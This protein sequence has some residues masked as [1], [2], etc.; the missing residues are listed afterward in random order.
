MVA[1]AEG[2]NND[3]DYD[4]NDLQAVA[5]L[6]NDNMADFDW[7]KEIV[8]PSVVTNG[9]LSTFK[10]ESGS[11]LQSWDD[12][13][14]ANISSQ[15]R[16]RSPSEYV[17]NYSDG[18]SYNSDQSM[19]D[20]DSDDSAAAADGDADDDDD[21]N[22]CKVKEF[23]PK[24]VFRGDTAEAVEEPLSSKMKKNKSPEEEEIEDGLSG[25]EQEEEYQPVE[26]LL[27]LT[28]EWS[29]GK[30]HPPE[31]ESCCEEL[32]HQHRQILI[33]D[34]LVSK[35]SELP[36]VPPFNNNN[37]PNNDRPA[38]NGDTRSSPSDKAV[39]LASQSSCL[40]KLAALLL[41]EDSHARQLVDGRQPARGTGEADDT[42]VE[43]VVVDSEL[44]TGLEFGFSFDEQLQNC[45]F[46]EGNMLV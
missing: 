35:E 37:K 28:W 6:T 34:C 2:A 16:P 39:R 40:L 18:G 45:T 14:A 8:D 38:A 19:D 13:S 30:E 20:S 22:N 23:G 7:N 41:G 32:L 24:L 46:E 31:L 9:S 25:D 3:D 5:L 17:D 1:E 4:Y 26:D 44:D 43:A 10:V 27:S 15:F 12:P 21:D 11:S 36:I 42:V 33:Q 29:D